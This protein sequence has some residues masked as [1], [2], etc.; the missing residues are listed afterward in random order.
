MFKWKI[1]KFYAHKELISNLM[2]ATSLLYTPNHQRC[3]ILNWILMTCWKVSFLFNPEDAVSMITNKNVKC[4]LVRPQNSF[5]LWNTHFQMSLCSH[6]T[7]ALLNCVQIWLPFCVI[8]WHLQM[9]QC[10]V[11]TYRGFWY[12]SWACLVM[13]EIQ[14]YQRVLQRHLRGWR[15]WESKNLFDDVM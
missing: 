13:S 14:S 11:L 9:A 6:D 5:L 15:P 4:G 8:C 10:I 2:L 3:W 1:I 12:Y 7:M